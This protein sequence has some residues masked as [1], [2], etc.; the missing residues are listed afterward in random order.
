MATKTIETKAIIRAQDKTGATFAQVAQKLRGL[1]QTAAGA[2]RR[3][4]S[5]AGRMSAFGRQAQ[6]HKDIA[7]RMAVTG[8]KVTDID[9]RG[10]GLAITPAMIGAAAAAGATAMMA[11]PIIKNLVDA[12][13]RKLDE[14]LSKT[15]PAL[16]RRKKLKSPR[17]RP[18]FRSNISRYP[19]PKPKAFCATRE[20][21]SATRK[22]Q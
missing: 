1:E 11:A 19:R 3:M 4:D 16:I 12:A 21:S 6:L 20:R 7:S 18:F 10:A 17:P 5:V 22:A 9:R 2:S 14:Q 15:S 8:S 13:H